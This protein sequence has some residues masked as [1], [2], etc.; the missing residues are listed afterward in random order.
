M[1]VTLP[2]LYGSLMFC[3]NHS[4]VVVAWLVMSRI[5]SDVVGHKIYM[6]QN[7]DRH[8]THLLTPL[9]I[10]KLCSKKLALLN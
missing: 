10:S 1:V 5:Q 9:A 4:D 6:L 2:I 3:Y 8:H 7:S